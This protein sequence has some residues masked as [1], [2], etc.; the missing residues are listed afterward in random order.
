MFSRNLIGPTFN[1]VFLIIYGTYLSLSLIKLPLF[2]FCSLQDHIDRAFFLLR[3]EIVECILWKIIYFIWLGIVFIHWK[4]DKN[5]RVICCF[6]AIKAEIDAYL[7]LYFPMLLL[8][9]LS[10]FI[11]SLYFQPGV[12]PSPRILGRMTLFM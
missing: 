4:I 8:R 10:M 7:L 12:K 9:H 11:I 2:P 1:S 3:V 6:W 5:C